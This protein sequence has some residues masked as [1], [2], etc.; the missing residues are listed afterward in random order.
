VFEKDP[1]ESLY[2]VGIVMPRLV[3]VRTRWNRYATFGHV[4]S[5]FGRLVKSRL[6]ADKNPSRK[7]VKTLT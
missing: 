2:P 1:L 5:P 6:I 7:D 3:V 4:K